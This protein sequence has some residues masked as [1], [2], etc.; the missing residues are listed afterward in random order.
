MGATT[1]SLTFLT[2]LRMTTP[3][4]LLSL[5]KT[6]AAVNGCQIGRRGLCQLTAI[7]SQNRHGCSRDNNVILARQAVSSWDSFGLIMLQKRLSHQQ[8]DNKPQSELG[9]MANQLA[10]PEGRSEEE[11]DEEH[12]KTI[13]RGILSAQIKLVKSFSL[14]TS[15]IGLGCQPLIYLKVNE[16]G[17]TSLPF[18][19]AGGA[20]L[21]FFTFATP[22][23]IHWVSKKY[24]TE[25]LYNRIENTY[26][27][28]T[29]TFLLRKKQITFKASDVKVPDIP[30]MFTTFQV[31]GRPLFVDGG[32]FYNPHHYGKLMGYDKPLDIRFKYDR[33]DVEES[34]DDSRKSK[35]S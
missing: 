27:S 16:A 5:T 12:Q 7:V 25:M 6:A 22:M 29:Y 32:A 18:I 10:S 17:S 33:E 21:S 2:G 3:A 15:V 11:S 1:T 23:L 19:V 9:E 31:N 8:V 34:L 13:Y 28:V 26:T 35:K 14:M 24:V 30:G 20:F 4:A